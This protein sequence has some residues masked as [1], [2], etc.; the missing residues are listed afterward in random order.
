MR[1][2]IN[3][4]SEALFEVLYSN[5]PA[6]FWLD[7]ATADN[8]KSHSMTTKGIS[9]L[10]FLGAIDTPSSTV[11]EYAKH[12]ELF[13]RMEN[14]SSVFFNTSIFGYL[15]ER[16]KEDRVRAVRVEHDNFSLEETEVLPF[17][18]TGGFFGYLGYELR[19]ESVHILTHPTSFS[20]QY[21]YATTTADNFKKNKWVDQLNH[22]L[23]LF[24]AP[25]R[26]LVYDHKLSLVYVVATAESRRDASDDAK[27]LLSKVELAKSI[28]TYS[29][30]RSDHTSSSLDTSYHLVSEKSSQQ[31]Y[32]S[33]A[34]CSEYISLGESYELCLTTQF[35]GKID[36]GQ[37]H[38]E[39]YKRLRSRNAAPFSCFLHYDASRLMRSPDKSL[40]WTK[41][42]G[43]SICSSSP[44]RYLSA[45]ADGFIESK[46]I[47]GTARRNLD[48]PS[49]D[50][51]ISASLSHDE[52]SRAENLMIVDLVRND[53]GRV[54]V[55]GSVCVPK[56]MD[57]ETYA[58]VHQL[59]ST[60][61]GKLNSNYNVIDALIATFP[62]GSMTGAP[63]IRT[64]DIIDELEG[65]PRGIYSG[66]LGYIG[67]NGVTDLNIVIRTAIIDDETITVGAGG[68]IVA[69]SNVVGEVDEVILKA[70]AVSKSIGKDVTWR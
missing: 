39:Y 36:Q 44:E 35:H 67:Y 10:S 28:H 32:D 19:S 69:Q 31:Y 42:G 1:T 25:S 54:C 62:G 41:M 20:S 47:K 46:P 2:S 56:L 8:S 64:M 43:F 22:P 40:K 51:I 6:S 66:A 29:H 14:G 30:S 55:P 59:V 45:T 49:Q 53:F 52:K 60:I 61:R 38:I 33:I 15:D 63:K 27:D 12:N 68:A 57:V 37:S 9:K 16:L 34:A 13:I 4:S 58:S 50:E 3:I 70:R 21:D 48:D 24:M 5:H 23:A 26:Y 7:S 11:L 65:R 17:N 18:F